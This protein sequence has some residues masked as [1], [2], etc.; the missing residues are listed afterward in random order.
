MSPPFL[1]RAENLS[2]SY[3]V[4]VP[5]LQDLHWHLPDPSFT[6]LMGTSGAGKSTLLHLI[7]GLD[8]SDEGR[9]W[10]RDQEVSRYGEA[11]WAVFR[12]AWIGMVFQDHNL[13]PYLTLLQ[14]VTLAGL[15]QTRNRE[16]V[17][18]AAHELFQQLGISGL[19]NRYPS[20]VSGGQRQRAAIARALINRPPLL[21]ADEPTGSLH[22]AASLAFL[23]L[24]QELH[25]GGQSILM[26][27]HDL[28]AA[29]YGQ[30]VWLLKDGHSLEKWP[31]QDSVGSQDRAQALYQWL[32]LHAW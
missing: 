20:E 28:Q 15:L 1:L 21:I 5:I 14:N 32:H 4:G 2:K 7:A 22:S 23:E 19:E 27:T 26:A 10:F 8:H 13:L 3:Q 18:N 29:S 11:E 31:A 17:A 30:E 24:L 12:R 16:E 25:A 6:I 9:L